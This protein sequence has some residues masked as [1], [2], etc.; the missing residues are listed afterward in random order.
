[1][2]NTT[3]KFKAPLAGITYRGPEA[4]ER[5]LAIARGEHRADGWLE[6]E[7][8]NQFDM[9]AVAVYSAADR[10]KPSMHIGY[11]PARNDDVRWDIH[12]SPDRI[13]A[14]LRPRLHPRHPNNPGCDVRFTVTS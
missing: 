4:R 2:S 6:P 13:K 12:A 9:L 14:S 11:L 5:L 3:R 1:M 7:D 8:D 10:G